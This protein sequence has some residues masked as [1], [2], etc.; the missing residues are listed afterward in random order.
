LAVPIAEVAR[1][2]L[3]GFECL[4]AAGAVV[5]GV[6]FLIYPLCWPERANSP[7]DLIGAVLPTVLIPLGAVV[8]FLIGGAIK[9]RR[10]ARQKQMGAGDAVEVTA[11]AWVEE[12]SEPHLAVRYDLGEEDVCRFSLYHARKEQRRGFLA[13]YLI[14]LAGVFAATVQRLPL[15]AGVPA[16]LIAAVLLP[17]G[18]R[19]ALREQAVKWARR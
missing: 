11:P 2:S 9:G 19:W 10:R 4:A 16:L 7:D 6:L 15:I 17:L 8:G 1:R 18:F 14:Y 12:P 3:C 13:L 5:A